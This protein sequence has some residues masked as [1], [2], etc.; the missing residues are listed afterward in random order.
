MI[1]RRPG[2]LLE[3]TGNDSNTSD[4]MKIS[5][6]TFQPFA[7]EVIPGLSDPEPRLIMFVEVSDENTS[8]RVRCSI[9]GRGSHDECNWTWKWD[10]ETPMPDWLR[11]FIEHADAIIRES[12]Q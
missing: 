12:K 5:G 2:R 8:P 10:G 3:M 11:P 9:C 6:V 1:S 4:N 7:I